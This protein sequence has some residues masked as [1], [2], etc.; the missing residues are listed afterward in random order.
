MN[1]KD[2]IWILPFIGFLSGYYVMHKMLPTTSIITPHLIGS[3][4]H[5]VLPVITQERL[6]LRLI[7]QKEEPYL[8]EGIIISQTPAGGTIIK[9]NQPLCIVTTKQPSLQKALSC[10][11]NTVE[12]LHEK[13]SPQAIQPRMYFLP[14]VYPENSC[15]AQYPQENEALENKKLVLYISAGNTKPIIW[16]NFKDKSLDEVVD[17]LDKYQIKPSII[18]DNNYA[19]ESN[20]GLIIVDQR[21]FA[22]TLLTLDEKKLLSVHLRVQT[23]RVIP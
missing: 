21:P 2:F 20:T 10:I 18:Y 14:H 5:T 8:P 4:V 22:G 9:Q 11:G 13:L 19:G 15:F 17:F 6:I 12:V 23:Q 16:P 7:S 1:A 3:H